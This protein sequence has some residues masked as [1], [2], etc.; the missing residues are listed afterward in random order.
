MNLACGIGLFCEER[1]AQAE[2]R[3]R[4]AF[5]SVARERHPSCYGLMGLDPAD[6]ATIR[7]A[8]ST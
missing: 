3:P 5:A 8:T 7:E 2:L 1:V 6:A 4:R